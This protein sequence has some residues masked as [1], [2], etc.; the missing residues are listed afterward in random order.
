[1]ASLTRPFSPAFSRQRL[2]RSLGCHCLKASLIAVAGCFHDTRPL[3]PTRPLATALPCAAT[4]TAAAVQPGCLAC[5][6]RLR[7]TRIAP[8]AMHP[9]PAS[10]SACS[11]PRPE[12]LNNSKLARSRLSCHGDGSMS[13]GLTRR[14]LFSLFARPLKATGETAKSVSRAFVGKT[15]VTAPGTTPSVPMVAIIQGRHCLALESFCSV[16]FERC[17][18]PGAMNTSQMIPM[19]VAEICTGCGICQQVCPAPENAV[20]MLP[21]R[22][23]DSPAPSKA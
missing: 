12:N 14:G 4:A 21:R 20:L 5:A 13:S 7:I 2:A 15:P 1:M 19:V 10:T 22:T 16:C 3:N 11:P 6:R 9:M 8:G 23:P 18:E 17:P